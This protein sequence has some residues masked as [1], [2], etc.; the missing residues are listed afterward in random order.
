MEPQLGCAELHLSD[1][2]EKIRFFFAKLD[3]FRGEKPVL[4]SKCLP[5]SM[6]VIQFLLEATDRSLQLGLDFRGG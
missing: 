5:R 2:A 3:H 4:C 6:L 1:A